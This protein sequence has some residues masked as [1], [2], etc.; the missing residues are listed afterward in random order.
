MSL[1]LIPVS[2]ENSTTPA[3]T[4]RST[5]WNTYTVDYIKFQNRN[6]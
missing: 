4:I 3:G 6:S 1:F 5:T 2:Q